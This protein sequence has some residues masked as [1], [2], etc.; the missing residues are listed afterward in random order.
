MYVMSAAQARFAAPGT[1]RRSSTFSATGRSWFESVVARDFRFV[2]ATTPSRRISRA[3][4]FTQ[5]VVPR[6][7]N[8]AWILGLP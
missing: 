8:S 3:T 4:V 5:Q 6:A 1:N 7:T 2:T